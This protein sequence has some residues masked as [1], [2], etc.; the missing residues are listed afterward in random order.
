VLTAD[1]PWCPGDKEHP[2]GTG[3]GGWARAVQCLSRVSF[4]EGFRER[5]S[6]QIVQQFWNRDLPEL[7]DSGE[8]RATDEVLVELQ[9]QDDEVLAFIK[10]LDDLFVRIDEEIQHEV[11]A[12]LGDYPRLIHA[13]RSAWVRANRVRDDR[14]VCREPIENILAGELQNSLPVHR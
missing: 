10:E 4:V 7:V 11:R 14:V 13:G 1:A 3:D 9:A 2:R 5:L 6:Y 12:I 8:L